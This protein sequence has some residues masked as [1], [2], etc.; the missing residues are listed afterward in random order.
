VRAPRQ[1]HDL[2]EAAGRAAT[3]TAAAGARGPGR[4][5]PQS[6]EERHACLVG[7]NRREV[8]AGNGRVRNSAVARVGPDLRLREPRALHGVLLVGRAHGHGDA[9]V[10]WAARAGACACAGAGPAAAHPRYGRRR[11]RR[12]SRAAS[13]AR[14]AHG[15]GRG[16]GG[17]LL[18]S[19]LAH[20]GR[21]RGVR[22]LA[23]PRDRIRAAAFPR[24]RAAAAAAAASNAALVRICH[25]WL[26]P[27]RRDPRARG[28]SVRAQVLPGARVSVR[29]SRPASAAPSARTLARARAGL[30][31]R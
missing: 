5:G 9:Q 23:R 8:V 6:A 24:F 10:E 14:S 13:A 20:H 2:D 19:A 12:G 30:E 22:R 3:T 15:R 21:G 26:R 18:V 17:G 25:H 4:R 1:R 11:G 31:Q 7:P 28:R 27:K 16:R 29:V